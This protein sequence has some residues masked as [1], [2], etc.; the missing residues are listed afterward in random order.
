MRM[1]PESH[2]K[3]KTKRP[4]PGPAWCI[5]PARFFADDRMTLAH[6]KVMA[7]ISRHTNELN[8]CR[9]RQT[10]IADEMGLARETVCRSISDL[11]AWGHVQKH[12]Y[13]KGKS[14]GYRVL[15]DSPLP[16]D[17]QDCAHDELDAF[18]QNEDVTASSH[19]MASSHVSCDVGDHTTCD[20]SRHTYVNDSSLNDSVKKKDSF[21]R[22]EGSSEGKG[23][24]RPRPPSHIIQPAQVSAQ[25]RLLSDDEFKAKLA[26]SKAKAA[27]RI[28]PTS[29]QWQA[30]ITWLSG[31]NYRD[32][33]DATNSGEIVASD[34][35]PKEGVSYAITRLAKREDRT[36]QMIGGAA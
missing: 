23:R 15:L 35:W 30:W 33:E 32:A 26:G 1:L 19:V 18:P 2:D 6:V 17:E 27:I 12:E 4:A 28:T 8:W 14:Y 29:V 25:S 9:L 34:N 11:I 13:R 5:I 36:L 16:P 20:D 21:S 10:T 7:S 24:D 3:I 31:R 22:Q